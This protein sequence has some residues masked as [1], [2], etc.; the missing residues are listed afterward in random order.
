MR[1]FLL[2]SSATLLVLVAAVIGFVFL[3][4]LSS[5]RGT[6]EE[7]AGAALG[8]KVAIAGDIGIER[9]LVPTLAATDVAIANVPGGSR[10]DMAR[11]GRL[12]F[13]LELLP[14]FR[15]DIR[16]THIL[17]A[18]AD[19]L[20]ER[21]PDGAGNWE[22]GTRDTTETPDSASDAGAVPFIGRLELRDVAVR[23][24]LSDGIDG[25]IEIDEAQMATRS[26]ADDVSID[27]DGR[28]N[29]ETIRLDAK[30]GS[31]QSLLEGAADWPLEADAAIADNRFSVKGSIEDPMALAGVSLELD[32]TIASVSGL[33]RA[34]GLEPTRLPAFQAH[35]TVEGKPDETL[36]LALTVEA[37][38]GKVTADG[39]VRDVMNFAGFRVDFSAEIE[40][41][42]AFVDLLG[43]PPPSVPAFVASGTVSGD[44]N[45]IRLAD[46][47]V[48]AGES[49]LS[50]DLTATLSA[51]PPTVT[52]EIHSKRLV[53]A[54]LAAAIAARDGDGERPGETQPMDEV[55][56]LDQP[57]QLD[58]LS[59]AN[60]DIRLSLDE[61]ILSDA[62]TREIEAAIRLQDRRLTISVPTARLSQGTLTASVTLN[63]RQQPPSARLDLATERFHLGGLLRDLQISD[64][65]TIR[66]DA[67]VKL[68]SSGETPRAMLSGLSGD[69]VVESDEG[70]VN[71]RFAGMFGQSLLTAMLPIG[72]DDKIE[73][74]CAI[75]HFTVGDGVVRSTAL[76]ADTRRVTVHGEGGADI[77][78][79]EVEFLFA[80]KTKDATLMALVAPV[81]VHGPFDDVRVEVVTSDVMA[82]M[83]M[84]SLLVAIVPY[85]IVL[86]FIPG[87]SD[88][89]E[90]CQ[91]ALFETLTTPPPSA[92]ERV[93]EGA[94][95][96]VGGVAEGAANV[97]GGVV[98]GAG[99]AIGTVG[100]G[101][102][103]ALG[104]LFG[105]GQ[106]S[107]ED[108]DQDTAPAE[109]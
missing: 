1:R 76:G 95:G 62:P 86:P 97:V 78:A 13:G 3:I 15:G 50:A 46:L 77:S 30:F 92:P 105:G 88:D 56:P 12:E 52:G 49:D 35:G 66:L 109:D 74:N 75:G 40:S 68:D 61:V 70:E 94:I 7:Q 10:E 72:D 83:A 22:I 63:G 89:P 43:A 91:A 60:I 107:D 19:I 11:I 8:R 26:F 100:R 41:L 38:G 103:G 36:D 44:R 96:A 28:L 42:E 80:S 9:S 51:D 87:T 81:R 93:V 65:L 73:I 82:N 2:W 6:I 98:G 17:L 29:G 4:D 25:H 64:A 104:G 24:A 45:E 99:G 79:Q 48:N 71:E 23:L 16:I 59:A 106:P 69:V 33:E 34:L 55:D 27:L 67:T 5:H 108:T 101:I 85:A 39:S 54:E 14:L 32:G 21:G 37:A 53:V 31:L 47:A 58:A 57:L 20:L 90:N 102:G 18:D 84:N